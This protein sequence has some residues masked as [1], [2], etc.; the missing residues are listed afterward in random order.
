MAGGDV[1]LIDAMRS[2]TL[3]S[4][5]AASSR[6]GVRKN[7][8]DKVDLEKLFLTPDNRLSAEWLNKLQQYPGGAK[9]R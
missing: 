1:E 3:S 8:Q 9:K 4:S 2:I 5:T 7:K 6:P